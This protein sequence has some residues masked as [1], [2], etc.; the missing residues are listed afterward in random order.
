MQ[1]FLIYFPRQNTNISKRTL[2]VSG[3]LVT[4]HGDA[5]SHQEL[6]ENNDSLITSNNELTGQQ[7]CSQNETTSTKQRVDGRL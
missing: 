3:F 1:Q 6:N 5:D 7:N 4:Q 2:R